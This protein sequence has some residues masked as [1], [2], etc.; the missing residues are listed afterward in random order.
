MAAAIEGYVA[1]KMNNAGHFG[2]R[3]E[4]AAWE[5]AC[6]KRQW[7]PR[8]QRRDLGHTSIASGQVCTG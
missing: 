8:S 4:E 7:S 1:G 3:A 6:T 5:L 2:W